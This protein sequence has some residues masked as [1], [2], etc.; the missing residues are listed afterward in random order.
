MALFAIVVAPTSSE[1]QM[2]ALQV[3]GLGSLFCIAFIG[4]MYGELFLLNKLR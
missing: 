4:M 1:D 3:A 2:L